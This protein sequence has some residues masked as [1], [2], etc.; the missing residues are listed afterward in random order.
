MVSY[1]TFNFRQRLS[2]GE[3]SFV[4]YR[5]LCKHA[6][7]RVTSLNLA[8][9]LSW[10]LRAI[11]HCIAKS[12]FIFHAVSDW[13]SVLQVRAWFE[14]CLKLKPVKWAPSK[15]SLTGENNQNFLRAPEGVQTEEIPDFQNVRGVF[16]GRILQIE[17]NNKSLWEYIK[18][19]LLKVMNVLYPPRPKFPRFTSGFQNNSGRL[20]W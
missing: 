20:W 6:H 11:G 8:W 10:Y 17:C 14:H 19:K 5:S 18:G 9:L 2:S 12:C 13:W 4:Q 15:Y 7:I 1:S 16:W 3:H